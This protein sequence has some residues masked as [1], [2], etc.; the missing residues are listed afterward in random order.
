MNIDNQFS[1]DNIESLEEGFHFRPSGRGGYIYYV[2]GG[3]VLPI[4][5]EMPV[6]TSE[7][8]C[9]VFGEPEHLKEFVYPEKREI[10]PQEA[11]IISGK[12]VAWL[13][14]RN[15]EHDIGKAYVEKTR[16]WRYLT[17]LWLAVFTAA[18]ISG[19]IVFLEY[20]HNP[21]GVYLGEGG[22]VHWG[23]LLDAFLSWFLPLTFLLYIAFVAFI[24][25]GRFIKSTPGK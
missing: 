5:I 18:L 17:R 8:D 24:F 9:L 15:I 23:N 14:S 4:G 16:D 12:L 11:A 1:D 21:G 19:V 25:L 10:S 22:D 13:A 6:S 20:R 3:Y 7:Y 2:E